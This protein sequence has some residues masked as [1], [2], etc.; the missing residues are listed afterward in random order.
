MDSFQGESL[1]IAATNHEGLLDP[2]VW[3]R[4][5]EVVEFNPPRQQDRALLLRLFLRGFDA[6]ALDTVSLARKTDRAT[7][8]DLERIALAAARS[9][10]LDGRHE[11]V[12]TDLEPALD[13]FTDR[14]RLIGK[15][16]SETSAESASDEV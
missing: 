6:S 16:A 13:E 8:A 15:L 1:L 14:R 10:V 11:V 7:G 2:A 12:P 4:F 5:D 3:R 9:A